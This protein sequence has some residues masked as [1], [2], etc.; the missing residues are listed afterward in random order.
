MT[1]NFDF[2]R[3]INLRF[4]GNYTHCL[5]AR[6]EATG[7]ILEQ[8]K[9]IRDVFLN[10]LRDEFYKDARKRIACIPF[11][12]NVVEMMN[13]IKHPMYVKLTSLLHWKRRYNYDHGS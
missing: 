7:I 13:D 5:M 3:T 9:G 6:K 8:G 4:V 12:R 11:M 2:F 10:D 1:H